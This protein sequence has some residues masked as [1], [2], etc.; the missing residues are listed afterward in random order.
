MADLDLLPVPDT[1]PLFA[2]LRAGLIAVL[3]QLTPA[4]WGRATMA[5]RW[6]VRDVAAHLLDGELR[7]LAAHRDGHRLAPERP[8]EGY[9]DV[10][11]LIERLN[12]GGVDFGAR[13]S[14]RLLTDLLEA[15]GGWMADFV[16]RLDPEAPA[17]FAVAWAGEAHSSN[18]FDT[19]REF[20]ER[21][22]HEMQIRAAVGA[23]AEPAALL[24]PR[25]VIPLLDTAVR[26]LPHAY[27]DVTA[28]E[29]TAVVLESPTL[30]CAW[31]LQRAAGAWRLCRGAADAPAARASAEADALWRL[32]FNA[33]PAERARAAFSCDGSAALLDALWRARS[34]MV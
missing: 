16:A 30:A 26:A 34:V 18:R 7:T 22:H 33:L 14:P 10:L 8:P 25:F 4:D 11:A 29:G 21:W 20:T 6:R 9:A 2:P 13:L 17:L 12:A 3:R 1:A 27:R 15:T 28:P 23:Q 31:T 24:E 5:G 32:F 19:A